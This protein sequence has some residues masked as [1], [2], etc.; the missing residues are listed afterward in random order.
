MFNTN[1]GYLDISA[2]FVYANNTGSMNNIAIVIGQN[3]WPSPG[4]ESYGRLNIPQPTTGTKY[5]LSLLFKQPN[6]YPI[7][8]VG[9]PIP[10]P[11]N[12]PYFSSSGIIYVT[13]ITY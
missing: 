1:S 3:P 6:P 4:F 11:Y 7:Y 13:I 5:T 9:T 2:S 8:Y 12:A 10:P